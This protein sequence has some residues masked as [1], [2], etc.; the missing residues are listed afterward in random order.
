MSNRKKLPKEKAK[1]A[2]C[3]IQ[4]CGDDCRVL[5]TMVRGQAVPKNCAYC[6]KPVKVLMRMRDARRLGLEERS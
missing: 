5:E 2:D 4:M 6:G 1:L 3:S